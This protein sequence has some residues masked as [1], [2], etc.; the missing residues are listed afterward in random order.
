MNNDVTFFTNCYERDWKT[1]IIEG[2]M[3]RKIENLNYNFSNKV[4]II[5]NVSDR[6]T[7]ESELTKIKDKKVIDEYY[8]TDDSSKETLDFFDI[9][10]D[11]FN[12]GYWYSI[13]PLTAILKCE[14]EYMLYLT[15]DVVVENKDYNWIDEGI[16]LIK[17]NEIIK[18]VNPIW[19][20]NHNE[21]QYEEDFYINLGFPSMGNNKD[22]FHTVNFSDQCFLIRTQDFKKKIYNLKDEL[23]DLHYPGY[24]GESFEKRVSSFLKKNKFYRLTSKN[25]TYYHPRWW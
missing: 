10:E 6:N 9:N 4:L 1:I 5:T 17:N 24:A 21:A 13:A 22:W 11:T 15:S 23:S 19:N 12:G 14:T 20:L 3:E 16:K 7:V 25:V 8:F 18:V 2:G